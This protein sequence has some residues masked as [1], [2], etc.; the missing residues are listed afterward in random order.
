MEEDFRKMKHTFEKSITHNFPSHDVD[1]T[2]TTQLIGY[3]WIFT[4]PAILSYADELVHR[5]TTTS[6]TNLGQTYSLCTTG[7]SGLDHGLSGPPIVGSDL[8]GKPPRVVPWPSYTS[9]R[10]AH[11]LEPSGYRCRPSKYLR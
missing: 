7:Q 4:N 11:M 2:A 9:Q 6:R 8:Y 5:S 3:T 10:L 1:A